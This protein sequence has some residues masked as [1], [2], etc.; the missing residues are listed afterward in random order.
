MRRSVRKC[1]TEDDKQPGDRLTLK[2]EG[3]TVSR[4]IWI[5]GV[6][7]PRN[8]PPT[9]SAETAALPIDGEKRLMS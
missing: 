5:D 8:L 2:P 9:L 6:V 7:T 3:G 4:E 1:C